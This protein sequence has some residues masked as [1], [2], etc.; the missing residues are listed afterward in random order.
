MTIQS[1]SE[2]TTMNSPDEKWKMY[3]LTTWSLWLWQSQSDV[4]TILPKIRRRKVRTGDSRCK[5][6]SA[7]FWS[8]S[9]LYL[10]SIITNHSSF[11]QNMRLIIVHLDILWLCDT[12]CVYILSLNEPLGNNCLFIFFP[13]LSLYLFH[14]YLYSIF[15]NLLEYM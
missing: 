5:D 9:S 3:N 15:I 11:N 13:S 10:Q 4:M 2:A 1:M 6:I 8:A 12:H 14:F 7:C